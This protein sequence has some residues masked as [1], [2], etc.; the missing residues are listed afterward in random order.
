MERYHYETGSYLF[1]N[2]DPRTLYWADYYDRLDRALRF[3]YRIP[4][5]PCFP[6][7]QGLHEPRFGI[8]FGL[9]RWR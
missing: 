2:Q 9:Y 4:N 7:A 8:G 3:G 6:N 5:P 1:F